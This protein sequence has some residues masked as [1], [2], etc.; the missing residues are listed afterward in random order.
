MSYLKWKH[1]QKL[2]LYFAMVISVIRKVKSGYI[3]W[4][5]HC[6]E[7]GIYTY[8]LVGGGWWYSMSLVYLHVVNVY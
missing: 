8:L 1:H 5:D 7:H 2:I 6:N 3:L 4:S